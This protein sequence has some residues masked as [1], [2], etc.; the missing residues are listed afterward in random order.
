MAF[1]RR[2][3]EAQRYQ[4]MLQTNPEKY[5]ATE[6][7]PGLSGKFLGSNIK[8]DSYYLDEEDEMTFADL[9][10]QVALIVNVLVSV[11]ASA[12]AIW[13][14]SRWWDTPIRLILSITGSMLVAV[15]EV[16]A[17]GGYLRRISEAKSKEQKLIEKKE[18]LD[19]WILQVSDVKGN[20]TDAAVNKNSALKKRR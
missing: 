19:A 15:A 5:A 8:M 9:S 18:V 13:V 20:K 10:R 1:L 12:I 4:H 11:I 6:Q 16:V 3:E 7:G 14:V 2:K 17:Y